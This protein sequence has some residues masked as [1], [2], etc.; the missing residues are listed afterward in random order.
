MQVGRLDLMWPRCKMLNMLASQGSSGFCHGIDAHRSL[1]AHHRPGQI[2]IYTS[3]APPQKQRSSQPPSPVTPSIPSR[4]QGL[5]L[6]LPELD[7]WP[8]TKPHQPP[9]RQE[10]ARSHA[11]GR[12]GKI[13]LNG[14]KI[15]CSRACI[16]SQVA[17]KEGG[18]GCRPLGLSLKEAG[19]DCAIGGEPG[20]VLT[21]QSWGRA[22]ETGK[23]CVRS[24]L[25]LGWCPL[26]SHPTLITRSPN[27]ADPWCYAHAAG[28]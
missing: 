3:C 24:S 25:L 18:Q 22:W 4:C 13:E 5:A 10:A 27:L 7:A 1:Q 17:V 12:R 2:A 6:A 11:A 15:T 28:R 8:V 26:V 16:R 21:S 20:D 23:F 9:S 14:A 19:I